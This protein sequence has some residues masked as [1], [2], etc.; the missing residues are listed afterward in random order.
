[1]APVPIKVLCVE[2]NP[3]VGDAIARKITGNPDFEWLGWVGS[4]AELYQKIAEVPPDVVCMDLDIPGENA[5]AMIQELRTRSPGSRVMILS[6]HISEKLV[7]EAHAAGA[8]GF[9]SKAEESRLIIQALKSV[10]AGEPAFSRLN[11]FAKTPSRALPGPLPRSDTQE[12]KPVPGEAKSKD[13]GL[14][15]FFRKLRRAG[16]ER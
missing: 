6:G 8:W 1:M 4:S 7:E 10:A 12:S 13:T 15:T 5:F 3:L 16:K 2:D 9:L 14:I 11:G